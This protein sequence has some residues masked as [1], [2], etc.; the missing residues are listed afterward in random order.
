MA[1]LRAI[2]AEECLAAIAVFRLMM[3]AAHIFVMGGREVNLGEREADIFRAGADGTMVGNYLTS[4]GDAPDAT[5]GMVDG[6]GLRLRP[7]ATGKAWSFRHRPPHEAD[8]N[9][10]AAENERRSLPVVR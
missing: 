9:V 8:W 7:P 1:D 4:A 3:P 6:Q 2:T 5:V 10:R